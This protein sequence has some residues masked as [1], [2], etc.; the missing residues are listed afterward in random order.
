MKHT[1]LV[2]E[3][4]IID[5]PVATFIRGKD[6]AGDLNKFTEY[7]Y[8]IVGRDGEQ[9]QL[10]N[11]A[12]TVEEI[13]EVQITFTSDDRERPLVALAIAYGVDGKKLSQ[14]TSDR[15]SMVIQAMLT[16]T[17]READAGRGFNW[18]QTEQRLTRDK[19][20]ACEALARITADRYRSELMQ[21]WSERRGAHDR[22]PLTNKALGESLGHFKPEI[23]EHVG[24]IIGKGLASSKGSL[25]TMVHRAWEYDTDTKRKAMQALAVLEE[26]SYPP[27]FNEDQAYRAINANTARA[28]AESILE[29]FFEGTIELT[30]AGN[31]DAEEAYLVELILGRHGDASAPVEMPD[32]NFM[33]EFMI[34]I[35]ARAL[36]A[37]AMQADGG[38]ELAMKAMMASG[39]K[40][41][42]YF[43]FKYKTMSHEVAQV[44]IPKLC[45]IFSQVNQ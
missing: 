44:V 32:T 38:D 29:I 26:V 19:R 1:N 11:G 40:G 20:M 6:N 13:H 24:R 39:Y 9:L 30:G 41:G 27:V 45:F 22:N 18:I 14:L 34:D 21:W 28:I 37:Q 33:L 35:V 2:T 25:I 42:D 43:D 17:H 16:S 3:L 8:H 5:S 10:G 15:V 12:T 23:R 7:T 31:I 4:H 36:R